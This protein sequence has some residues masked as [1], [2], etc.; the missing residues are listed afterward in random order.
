MSTPNEELVQD[1][2]AELENK[3]GADQV[4][5]CLEG[6]VRR[7]ARSLSP[8]KA[9]LIVDHNQDHP[10]LWFDPK[11]VREAF[12]TDAVVEIEPGGSVRIADGDGEVV[13]WVA[14]EWMAEPSVTTAIAN[15]V[16][17]AA[18]KGGDAVRERI[19]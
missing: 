5:D 6:Y 2:E 15:A 17:L 1:I 10:G 19:D 18:S 13:C 12:L 8:E 7:L 14:E 11:M 4:I 9:S 16:Y 3:D